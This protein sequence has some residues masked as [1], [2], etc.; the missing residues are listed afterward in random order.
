MSQPYALISD[1]ILTGF[2]LHVDWLKFDNQ[3]WSGFASG[4]N[5]NEDTSEVVRQLATFGPA[6]ITIGSELAN[7]RGFFK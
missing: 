7:N 6:R 3:S 2:C 4:F 1:Q 5:F